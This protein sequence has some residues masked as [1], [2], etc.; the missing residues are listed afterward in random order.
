M[1][2]VLVILEGLVVLGC[3]YL[4]VRTGG[5]GL[6]LWGGVGVAVL[7]FVFRIP[8]GSPPIDAILIILAV[9]LTAATMQAAGGR[10]PGEGGIAH[11]PQSPA[12]ACLHRPGRELPVHGGCGNREHLLPAYSGDLRC[13]LR[14]QDPTGAPASRIVRGLADGDRSESGLGRHG[15]YALG[16]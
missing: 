8:P 4:G 7:V 15:G 2:A 12:P 6:G 9:I 1:N 5:I 14:E 16:V 13:G 10:L 11:H 3:I